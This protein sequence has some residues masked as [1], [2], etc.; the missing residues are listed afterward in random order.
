MS[1]SSLNKLLLPGLPL[2]TQSSLNPQGAVVGKW[3][4]TTGLAVV[5]LVQVGAW[6]RLT[7]SGLS[8]TD[9]SPLG[10]PPP[11][12]LDAWNREFER[13]KSFPEWHQR[14]SMTLSEFQ[15]IYYWEYSHRMLG[16]T[17]GLVFA[18][19]W[20]YLTMRRK[21]PSGFQPRLFGLLAMGG[22]QGLVGWWMVKSGLGDDRRNDR[23]E[24]RVKPIRLAAHLSMAVA[25]YSALV[26]TGLDLFSLPH[27]QQVLAQRAASLSQEAFRDAVR[28]RTVSLGLAAW[29]ALTI[30][31]GALVAGSD[32][33]LAYNTFPTMNGQWI[34]T[35]LLEL[36][37]WHRN[38]IENTA[39]VQWN[40]RVLATTTA[41]TGLSL[42]GWGLFRQ[43]YY[44]T[45][46]F[47]PQVQRG[48][49][50]VGAS[51]VGQF[52]L[53]VSTL[54]LHVPLQL[55]A[56]HQLGALVVLTS[57]LYL[58][59]SL[60]YAQPSLR[61][62]AATATAT[63]ASSPAVGGVAAAAPTTARA[64]FN[65]VAASPVK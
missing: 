8:M 4:A 17:I 55:A 47:T 45:A 23:H 37:P 18:L 41:V 52:T 29:T 11:T 56:A 48:L 42:A 58:A 54:L 9:W 27:T 38:V 12:N 53:G 19:P 57:S 15:T 35:E 21:I 14:Q 39:T 16:R 60:R 32:A 2:M 10:G 34:P 61:R 6:T 63:A 64:W 25:T 49:F 26:W 65:K 13:Y 40:H 33:G 50:A 43:P 36:V 20:M 62:L 7:K 44:R 30:A 28:I 46:T 24:I 59:H 31:S 5:G 51:V 3:I 1:S 22:T